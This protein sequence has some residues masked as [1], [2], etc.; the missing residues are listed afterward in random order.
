ML[1][2]QGAGYVCRAGDTEFLNAGGSEVHILCRLASALLDLLHREDER[3]ERALIIE[4]VAADE[5][6]LQIQRLLA[7]AGDAGETADAHALLRQ[8]LLIQLAV[9]V[10]H[11]PVQRA[12]GLGLLDARG[13]VADMGAAHGQDSGDGLI[14]AEDIIRPLAIFPRDGA[15]EGL[16]PDF[17]I[18]VDL[19]HHRR[20]LV[21]VRE[22]EGGIGGAFAADLA[23]DI[24]VR[25]LVDFVAVL[26]EEA[27]ADGFD[28]LLLPAG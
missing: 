26:S 13:E 11:L 8:L 17:A 20:D 25:V 2:G 27:E 3:H 21:L 9:E 7:L 22:E 16:Q 14:I 5:L 10:A 19:A 18:L 6:V 1:L 24:R 12:L 4:G 23:Y 28:L 15:A